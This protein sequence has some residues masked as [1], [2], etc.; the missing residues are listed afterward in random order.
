LFGLIEL[1]KDTEFIGGQHRFVFKD[2]E[3]M[4]PKEEYPIEIYT[5]PKKVDGAMRELQCI[6]EKPFKT[7]SNT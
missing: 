2:G 5:V 7:G 4:H 3:R 6:R 1:Q